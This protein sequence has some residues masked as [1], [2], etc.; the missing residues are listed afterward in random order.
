MAF[1]YLS[2]PKTART[3]DTFAIFEIPAA[4]K[5]PGARY[6]LHFCHFQWQNQPGPMIHSHF[7][8]F[9]L[10][11]KGPEHD[12]VR[13]FATSNITNQ[14]ILREGLPF[15]AGSEMAILTTR[16]KNAYKKIR[17][18]TSD[19]PPGE[20][21]DKENPRPQPLPGKTRED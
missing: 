9:L 7:L 13:I 16:V 1:F 4:E 8:K 17:R 18:V 11:R 20:D 21:P 19:T 12:T 14:A 10:L 3:Y 15:L 2:L 6:C 5:G